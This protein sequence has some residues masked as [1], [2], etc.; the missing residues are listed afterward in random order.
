[1]MKITFNS[2]NSNE[3]INQDVDIFLPLS[4]GTPVDFCSRA[5]TR[6]VFANTITQDE[7]AFKNVNVLLKCFHYK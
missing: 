3:Y 5:P 1:M 2:D 7:R 4:P 6:P